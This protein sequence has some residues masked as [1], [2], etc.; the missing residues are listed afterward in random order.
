MADANKRSDVLMITQISRSR[1]YLT[2]N[3]SEAV[4]DTKLLMDNKYYV[5]LLKGV[6]SNDLEKLSEIFNHTIARSVCDS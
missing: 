5:M 3:I 4:R 2:L 1:H 6:I